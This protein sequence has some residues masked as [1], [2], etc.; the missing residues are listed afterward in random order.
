MP[1]QVAYTG[2]FL[3]VK[4]LDIGLVTVY[5][6]V[7]GISVAKWFDFMNGE[8]NVKE[9]Q[10]QNSFIMF[11]DII[12]QLFLLGVIAYVLRNMVALIPYP[13][14]GVAGFQHNRLKELNGGPVLEF[15]LIF[16]QQNLHT[17]ISVFAKKVL[18]IKGEAV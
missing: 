5:F 4:L 7:L 17:K 8:L 13:F 16:F 18:G 10:E 1:K 2:T 14:E 15:V 12:V 6:F 11:L 3:A 9:Y